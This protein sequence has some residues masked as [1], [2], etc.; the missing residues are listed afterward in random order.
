R[1]S[2]AR[3]P[4]VDDDAQGR[5]ADGALA[6]DDIVERPDVEPRSERD[7]GDVTEPQDLAL[8]ELVGERLSRHREISV[9]LVGDVVPGERRVLDHE[10]D[11]LVPAPAEGVEA[12][13]DDEAARS[14]GVEG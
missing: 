4:V 8:A 14:P 1:R 3:D 10:P 13:V 12:G 6:E 5:E 2:A 11:R 7:P 9:D